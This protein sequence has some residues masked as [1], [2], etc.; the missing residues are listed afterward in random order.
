[1]PRYALVFDLDQPALK[2]HYGEPTTGAILEIRR[3]LEPFGFRSHHGFTYIG[4][5]DVNAATCVM[6][7]I[8]LVRILPWF[9]QAVSDLHMHRIEE[10]TELMSVIRQA[11]KKINRQRGAE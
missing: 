7:A 9:A 11:R 5:E 4:N 8:A 3:V 6:A 2:K 1:M 10:S